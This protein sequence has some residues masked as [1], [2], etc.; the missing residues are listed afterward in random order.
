MTARTFGRKGQ[1]DEA[2]M[3]R[4][5]EAFIASERARKEQLQH[6]P[7][8]PAFAA[9]RPLPSTAPA[10][11]IFIRE[12]SMPVAYF[13]WFF[14]G[15]I[16]AHRFYLGLPTSGMIQGSMWFFGWLMILAGE[17]FLWPVP[18]A[19]ALWVLADAFMIPG[20]VREANAR[21]RG[22]AVH[23]VFT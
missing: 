11:P 9:S 3:A 17:W 16:G 7:P 12:K 14:C 18:V 5:R 21:I 23:Y 19:A 22:R 1:A 13:F 2:E 20:L 4:R 15:A 6:Q 10:G 8:E